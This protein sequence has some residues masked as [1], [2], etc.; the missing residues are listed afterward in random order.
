MIKVTLDAR[1]L[2]NSFSVL[3]S[4]STVDKILTIAG[5]SY[6]ADINIF[7]ERGYAFKERTGNLKRSIAWR[8]TGNRA[9]T[10]V[11]SANYATYVERGHAYIK[12]WRRM[13]NGRVVNVK[14]RTKAYPF[15]LTHTDERLNDSVLAA[16]ATLNAIVNSLA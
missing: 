16:Q 5:E 13:K 2:Q 9:V 11:P 7:I 3:A 14:A 8:P 1:G 4:Q 6:V 10:V 15:M 12:G